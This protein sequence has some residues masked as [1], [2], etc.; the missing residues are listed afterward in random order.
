MRNTY[1]TRHIPQPGLDVLTRDLGGYDINADDHP[2]SRAELIQ[3]IKGRSAVVCLLTDIFDGEV[4]DA[5]GP[6]LKIVANVA[7]GY[8]NIDVAAATARGIVVSNTPGVLT[9]TTAD[10]AWTLMMASA[11]RLCEAERFLRAGKWTGWGIMQ[12]LGVDISGKTL[13]LVGA[14]RIGAAVARRARGFDMRVLYVEPDAKPEMDAL[15]AT[16]VDLKTCLRQSDFVSLHVPLL[17]Q[18][19]HLIGTA[20]LALMQPTAHLINTAR[21]PVI[22]EAALVD[23]LKN[24]VIAG[25]GLDVF[26][27]EP[28]LHPGLFQ[29]ENV[30]LAPHI[31]SASTET[32]SRMAIMAA[33]NCVAVLNGRIAPNAVDTVA[34]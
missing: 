25:A 20:E 29:L 19:R 21:G 9:D 7:V 8:N 16:L 13:G 33:E 24:K 27:E 10:F 5:A 17:P 6:Q 4:F 18:T 26:E 30:V 31:A 3:A 15:G 28:K 23:A 1:V 34:R 11:R 22:D 12:F 14:G 2:F 32:R